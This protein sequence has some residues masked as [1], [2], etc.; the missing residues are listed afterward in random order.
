LE[1][2]LCKALDQLIKEINPW[3]WPNYLS[4][5]FPFYWVCK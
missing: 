4:Y 2:K 3:N 5:F 1:Q